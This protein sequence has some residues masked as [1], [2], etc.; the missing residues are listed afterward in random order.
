MTLAEFTKTIKEL[1]PNSS[2]HFPLAGLDEEIVIYTRLTLDSNYN[3]HPIG[4]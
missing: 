4:A 1:F 2:C 3:V